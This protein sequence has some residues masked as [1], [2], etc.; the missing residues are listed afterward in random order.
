[1]RPGGTGK[2]PRARNF[3]RADACN[4]NGVVQDAVTLAADAAKRGANCVR[5]VAAGWKKARA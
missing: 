4:F 2:G 1:M 3:A 5:A